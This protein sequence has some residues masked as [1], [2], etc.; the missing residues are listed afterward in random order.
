MCFC[1]KWIQVKG[2]KLF[3][4][5][6]RISR[7]YTQMLKLTTEER[8]EILLNQN[9]CWTWRPKLIR[10]SFGNGIHRQTDSKTVWQLPTRLLGVL[11]KSQRLGL[12]R[13]AW[14]SPT[15]VWS[16]LSY[17]SSNIFVWLKCIKNSHIF[18]AH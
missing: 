10:Q 17:I 13:N 2:N 16:F 14:H 7:E 9:V 15:R 18:L 1:R 4:I 12:P 11:P 6:P 5:N 3:S 8:A